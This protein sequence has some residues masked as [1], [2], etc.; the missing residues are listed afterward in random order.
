MPIRG[1]GYSTVKFFVATAEGIEKLVL[2][3]KCGGSP[4]LAWAIRANTLALQ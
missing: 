2:Y 3:R 1:E 4:D